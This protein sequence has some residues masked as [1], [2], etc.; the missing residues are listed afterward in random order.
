MKYPRKEKG[1]VCGPTLVVVDE[2][3]KVAFGVVNGDQDVALLDFLAVNDVQRGAG[4]GLGV[5]HE[6]IAVL[7]VGGVG[8]HLLRYVLTSHRPEAFAIVDDEIKVVLS[9]LGDPLGIHWGLFRRGW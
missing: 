8:L 6:Q 1:R 2:L 4:T 5:V 3:L 9:D 7:A